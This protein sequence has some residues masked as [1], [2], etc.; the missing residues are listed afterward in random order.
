MSGGR[1]LL[2][3]L[4]TLLL[5]ALVLEGLSWLGLG[6]IARVRGPEYEPVPMELTRSQR[7]IIKTLLDPEQSASFRLVYSPELGWNRNPQAPPSKRSVI[8]RQGIRASREFPERPPPGV[9]RVAAFGDSFTYGAGVS[10]AE[11]WCEQLDAA[12]P[13]VEVLNFG[14]GA[15]GPGPSIPTSW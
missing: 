3:P 14:V 15:Y 10:N 11:S 12:L 13:E 4:L 7:K 9:L 2:F 6:V 5:V 8:N 1:R